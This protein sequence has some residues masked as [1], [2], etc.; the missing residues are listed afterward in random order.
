MSNILEKKINSTLI[1]PGVPAYPGTPGMPAYTQTITE[2]TREAIAVQYTDA[3]GNIYTQYIAGPAYETVRYVEHPAV[4]GIP[5]IA[6]TPPVY[7]RA[8]SLGWSGGARSIASF[9]EGGHASF[10]VDPVSVGTV[11]GLNTLD[12]DADYREIQHGFMTARGMYAVV[13]RGVVMT[14]Y[15]PFTAASVFTVL[16]QGAGVS[17]FVG[18]DSV[19]SS[20]EPSYGTV[21]L[22]SSLYSGGDRVIDASIEAGTGPVGVDMGGYGTA[23]MSGISALGSDFVY[24][25]G[26]AV[27]EVLDNDATGFSQTGGAAVMGTLAAMGGDYAYAGSTTALQPVSADGEASMLSPDLVI[28]YNEMAA[29]ITAGLS[30]T[31]VGV[32]NP[33]TSLNSPMGD[34]PKSTLMGY[35]I[36]LVYGAGAGQSRTIVDN[37]FLALKFDPL[38]PWTTVPDGTT[39]FEIRDGDTVL[40]S[41]F[42]GEAPGAM[43]PMLALGSDYEYA[44]GDATMAPMSSSGAVAIPIS[45]AMITFGGG[46]GLYAVAN[47]VSLDGF[48][49]TMPL[50]SVQVFAGNTG[51]VGMSFSVVGE[52]STMSVAKA[53]IVMPRFELYAVASVELVGGA[54]VA[55]S[56]RF[57]VEAYGAAHLT[58]GLLNKFTVNATMSADS[59]M[60]AVLAMPSPLVVATGR[61]SDVSSAYLTMPMLRT[62]ASG[63]ARLT[64]SAFALRALASGDVAPALYEGYAVNLVPQ[65]DARGTVYPEVSHYIGMP[66]NQI[67]RFEDEYYGVAADGLYLLG[68]DT[69]NG[70]AI[71]WG[72]ETSLTD[73]GDK[74]MKRAVSVYVGGRLVEGMT[75]NVF[76]GEKATQPYTYG[77]PRGDDAQNYRVKFGKGMKS[78]YYAFGLEDTAGR[79]FEVDS[80][81]FEIYSLDRAI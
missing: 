56:E 25:G 21:F 80:L 9:D 6:G 55:P 53:T 31:E 20:T 81:D 39:Y 38:D 58:A 24:S 34:W 72:F 76:V 28:V 77:T 49:G 41:G 7:L 45:Y 54:V 61:R 67:V 71:G 32:L 27:F 70:A 12:A 40:Y 59:V 3:E 50:P 63:A 29:P 30:Q 75:A 43:A 2:I 37:S 23:T 46:F 14:P 68:G 15:L 13:E 36:H 35:T 51:R 57:K 47:E 33:F 16:R 78:R 65:D 10:S 62:M 4:P 22:D 19:Y 26:G 42:A 69:D 17:Y 48:Q 79:D 5:P 18:T 60:K 8:Y 74:Q 11:V 73:F 44:G 1:S 52:A 66:F 64:M